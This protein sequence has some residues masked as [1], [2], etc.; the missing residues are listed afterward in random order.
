MNSR[1]AS[2]LELLG[3]ENYD[4]WRLQMQAVLI[5]NDLWDYVCGRCKEPETETDSSSTW[6]RNDLKAR[7]DI[8]LSIS[9][10]EL[11]QVK[12]YETL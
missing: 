12:H 6:V 10:T 1:N 2:I 4:T 5:K 7:S 11:K 3:R 9:P 8:I